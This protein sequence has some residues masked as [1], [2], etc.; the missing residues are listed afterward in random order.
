MADEDPRLS[1][2]YAEALRSITQQQGV[3]DQLRANVGTLLGAMSL[4]TGFL[5]GLDSRNGFGRWGWVATGAFIVAVIAVVSI[6]WPR[7]KWRFRMNTETLLEGYVDAKRPATLDEMHR[8]LAGF[9]ERDYRE[10]RDRL[11]WMCYIFEGAT[12]VIVFEIVSWI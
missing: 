7:H 8:A 6:L 11:R 1:L 12:A 5:A 4:A 2:V 9:L 3:L 10:N